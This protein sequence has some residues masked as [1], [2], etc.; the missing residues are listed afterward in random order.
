MRKRGFTLNEMLIALVIIGIITAATIPMFTLRKKSK[1]FEITSVTCAQTEL[2]ANLSST[3]CAAAV[4]KA[5]F[6]QEKAI[7]TLAFLVNNGQNDN[8]KNAAG[9]ILRQACDNGGDKAC[10]YFVTA[11]QRDSE[12]CDITGTSDGYDLRHYLEL[13]PETNDSPKFLVYDQ[14]KALY[15]SDNTN[16]K[17][18]VDN[19]C[20]SAGLLNMACVIN[21]CTGC[22]WVRHYG[23]TGD[24]MGTI[25]LSGEYIYITGLE[26]SDT[27]GNYDMFVTKIKVKDGTVKWSKHYGGANIDAAYSLIESGGSLYAAS[28]T[29][30]DDISVMKLNA[31]S[32]NIDWIRS[33]SGSGFEMPN[34]MAISGNFIYLTGNVISYTAG[35]EDVVVMKINISDGTSVWTKHYGGTG[36]D[37]GQSIT[38]SPDGT[39]IYVA[40]DTNS[41]TAGGYDIF[42]MKINTTT[43]AADWK[44]HYGGSENDEMDY[45]NHIVLSGSDLYV[46]GQSWDNDLL[47]MKLNESNGTAQW[48]RYYSGSS[49]EVGNSIAVSGSFIYITGAEDSY[50]AGG[51]DVFVMKLNTSDGSSVWQNHYGGAGDDECISIAVS[52]NDIYVAGSEQSDTAG[53]YD[54]L[55]MRLSN[56]QTTSNFNW[57]EDNVN[58]IGNPYWTANGTAIGAGWTANGVDITWDYD[59]YNLL[60]ESYWITN[61]GESMTWTTN[62]SNII[63]GVGGWTVGLKADGIPIP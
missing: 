30:G 21:G 24:D 63:N 19:T 38:A 12:L 13:I 3:A 29:W 56:N 46:T 1:D 45:F 51:R 16:I 15:D 17:N 6:G 50:T 2:A 47:I 26:T 4:Q 34:A 35:Q 60:A 36:H 18:I 31:S 5:Q 20:C 27:A 42:V 28:M 54:I 58:L 23:G 11:C 48:A 40:G 7:N 53:D 32:G 10:N 9:K 14:A 39:S 49:F 59:S 25:L 8:I 37:F 43:G 61:K 55:V 22:P 52:G 62:G 33:F 44:K 41:D 57:S